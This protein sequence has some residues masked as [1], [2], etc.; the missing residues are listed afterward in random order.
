MRSHIASASI[1]RICAN[2]GATNNVGGGETLF[3]LEK[4]LDFVARPMPPL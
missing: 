4:R 2:G 3:L 1:E